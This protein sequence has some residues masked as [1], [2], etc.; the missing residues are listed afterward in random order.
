MNMNNS[1]QPILITGG[2]GKTGRRVASRLEARGLPVR[3]GS[4]AGTP[5][6]DWT[7]PSTWEPALSGASAAYLAYVPDLAVPRAAEHIEQFA[8]L[9]LTCGVSRLVLLSGRGEEGALLSEQALKQPGVDW[10]IIRAS[11]FNQNFSE[12][13]LLDSILSGVLALPVGEVTEPFV[14]TD[15]IADVAVAALTEERH[16]GQLYELTGPRLLTFAEVTGEIA[17]ASGRDIRYVPLTKDE[18]VAVLD[19]ENLPP[20]F[21]ALLIELF[22]S[23]LDG[24]NSYLTDGVYRALGREPRD[25]REYAR[26]TA[27]AGVWAAEESHG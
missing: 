3:I 19:Q 1:N 25:F 15:D 11:W 20:D 17:Q 12:S 16:S 18:F 13:F 27:A 5:P 8:R 24:R 6:F 22:T 2:T 21:M 9:A 23:V 26:I 7:D 4:R 10:T 14:D